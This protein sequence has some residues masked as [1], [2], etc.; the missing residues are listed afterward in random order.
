MPHSLSSVSH[1]PG[2]IRLDLQGKRLAEHIS[3]AEAP[4][5]SSLEELRFHLEEA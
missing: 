4:V 2:E 1:S 3:R 5:T